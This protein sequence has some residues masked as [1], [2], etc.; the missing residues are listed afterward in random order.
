MGAP[1][2]VRSHIYY[3]IRISILRAHVH[4]MI[5]AK[6]MIGFCTFCATIK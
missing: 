5:A 6:V 2:L 3:H 1:H 4:A